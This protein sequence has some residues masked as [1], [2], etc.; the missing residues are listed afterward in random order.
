MRMGREW[1]AAALGLALFLGG[2]AQQGTGFGLDLVPDADVR[3]LGLKEWQDLRGQ[4][5]ASDDKAARAR[6]EQVA[7]RVLAGA[8]ENP[9]AWE[10]VLFKSA[11]INAFALPGNKIGV[12]EGMLAVAET[13]DQLAA[14]IGHEIGHNKAA[15]A[16]QRLNT[17]AAT[18]I[19]VNILSATLGGADQETTAAL[20]GAGAQYG[21]VLPYSRNQESE[22]DLMGL[23]YMARA[24]YDPR[25]AV[26]L[27]Q[28]M[29]QASGAAPP[30]FM[31][32]HPATGERIRA[33]EAELPRALAEFRPS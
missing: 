11:E 30:A 12:F 3:A 25:A 31:S 32:T 21:I 17:Q 13:D 23:H 7:R 20:L 15:H 14:V 8:G 22:A 6:V 28:R 26:T 16:K 27:W 1:L 24:G 2:C 33:I 5:P 18:E 10:V 9:A 29:E 4:T 19:G